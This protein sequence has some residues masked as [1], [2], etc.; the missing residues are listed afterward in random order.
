MAYYP[1]NKIQTDLYT[2]GGEYRYAEVASPTYTNND[3]AYIGYYH[4]LYN[5]KVYTGRNPTDGHPVRELILIN[6]LVNDTAFSSGIFSQGRDVLEMSEETRKKYIVNLNLYNAALPTSLDYKNGEYTRYF[7]LRR[8]QP[9]FT[10]VPKSTFDQFNQRSS[11]VPWQLHRTLSIPWKLTGNRNQVALIN[12][13]ITELA[14]QKQN[15]RGL[16]IFLKKN[17]AQFYQYVETSNLYSNGQTPPILKTKSGEIYV[18]PYHIHP[19]KGP[20][21]GNVHTDIYHEQLYYLNDE[22]MMVQ[23]NMK[24]VSGSVNNIMGNNLSY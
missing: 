19:S 7:L 6:D 8:N 12:K 21:V 11:N 22:I 23:S 3:A 20:M 17:W 18:G 24:Q 16:S 5:N 13:N 1:K 14:E 10:E 2:N 15:A 4:K 9:I